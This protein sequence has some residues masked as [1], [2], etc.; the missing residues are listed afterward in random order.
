MRLRSSLASPERDPFL[1]SI[2]KVQNDLL[3]RLLFRRLR[4]TGKSAVKA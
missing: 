3:A 2:K 1:P 4:E